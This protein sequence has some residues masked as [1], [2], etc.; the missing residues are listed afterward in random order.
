MQKLIKQLYAKDKIILFIFVCVYL[1]LEIVNIHLPGL[2]S[3]E[4]LQGCG[5]L[6]ILKKVPQ[7]YL[8]SGDSLYFPLM[9]VPYETAIES[10]ILLPFLFLFGI[11]IVGLRMAPVII[12]IFALIFTYLFTKDF[13]NKKTAVIVLFLLVINPSFL[14]QTKLG[15]NSASMIQ[16]TGMGALFFLWKWYQTRNSRYF[17]LSIFL[18]GLG[19]SIRIW[20]LWFVNGLI[21]LGAPFARSLKP[22]LKKRHFLFGTILFCLG[23]LPFIVYN[24]ISR[25]DTVR[26][27]IS[28]FKGSYAG[29]NNLDYINNLK[30]RFDNL[31][32]C[33]KG[34]YYF[35]K[36]ENYP[37]KHFSSNPAAP[38]L[39]AFGYVWLLF[40]FIFK[41]GLFPTKKTASLLIL[42][43]AILL[44]SPFTLSNLAGPHLFVLYP[45]IQIILG[46]FFYDLFMRAKTG[47]TI[48]V[49]TIIL[50]ASFV[51]LECHVTLRNNY[52]YFY[53]TGGKGSYSDA[54]ISLVNYLQHREIYK[55]SLMDWGFQHNLVFLSQGRI[56]PRA[57]LYIENTNNSE[58]SCFASILEESLKSGKKKVFIFHSAYFT[59]KS[60]IY[61]LFK[62]SVEKAGKSIKIEEV[63]YQRDGLPVYFLY[64]VT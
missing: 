54:I 3:D 7:P 5:A 44:Q 4:A 15:L 27:M 33:I 8:I 39:F 6:Q 26:Y 19:V 56:A 14:L 57:F 29:V 64:S 23:I 52:L 45:L 60:G 18:L 11:N 31:G 10:Y 40:S 12:G 34:D 21:L 32:S 47:R 24:A 59:I 61:S 53:K 42:F 30:V 37:H 17:Y 51:I 1:F 9:M 43:S 49:I 28:H 2:F 13:F 41:K 46:V 36:Q 48:Q 63:F 20:F 16:V 25:F 62:D 50:F 35:T 55:P 38:K 22:R 58:Q